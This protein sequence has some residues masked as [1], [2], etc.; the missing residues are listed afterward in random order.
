MSKSR[1]FVYGTQQEEQP[2]SSRQGIHRELVGHGVGWGK[3]QM[4]AQHNGKGETS[5]E[6]SK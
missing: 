3:D 1:F 6:K 5:T 2:V 4:L